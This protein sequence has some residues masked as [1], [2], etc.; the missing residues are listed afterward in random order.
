MSPPTV[1]WPDHAKSQSFAIRCPNCAS[2]APK[3]P[4][5]A[6]EFT[7]SPGSRK[8]TNVVRCPDCDCPFYADQIP[9]DYAEEAMLERGRVPFYLQL[10]AGLSLITRPLAQVRAPAGSVYAEIGCGFGFGLDYAHHAKQWIGRGIDPGGI[11][12]LGQKMLGVTI[13][14]RY[15]GRFRACAFWHM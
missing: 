12:S 15:L 6:I 5:L 3:S 1:T 4:L 13:E 7:T 8:M 2:D 11:S 14:S 10:G 9:P